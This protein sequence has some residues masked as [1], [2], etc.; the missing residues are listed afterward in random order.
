M[1]K[2]I[3]NFRLCD[4]FL[5]GLILTIST[6]SLL[7]IKSV[8]REGPDF[9][10][11][12]LFAV[13]IGLI[14]AL[15]LQN[16]DYNR[17][18]KMWLWIAI[19]S[20]LL[21]I[22]TFFFGI[23]VEGTLGVNAKAWIKIFGG[24]TFQ[25]SELVKIGFIITF[26]N[27][28]S[29]LQLKDKL[30]DFKHL[31]LVMFHAIL[32]MI[33]MHFQGDDGAA[34]IFFCITLYMMFTAGIKL[35]YFGIAL[36]CATIALPILWNFVMP[37]YQKHRILNQLNPEADPL[38][39]GYQQIQG[40]LSIGSGGIFGTGLFNG[41]RVEN[42]FVPIQESDFI[43]SVVGEELG[44]IGCLAIIFLIFLLLLKIILISKKSVNSLGSLICVGIVGFIASQ[45]M[46]NLGMCLSMLPVIG[47]TLPFFSAGGSSVT[48]LYLTIGLAQNINI[49]NR[50]NNKNLNKNISSR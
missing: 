17:I 28:L 40:K 11:I 19:F 13:V 29:K 21:L 14:C 48:C 27:H 4:K 34:I 43:F 31:I 42:K 18:A 1:L 47:V 30:N 46:F 49:H 15:I 33:F 16:I 7:L 8:S 39:M 25:P 23:A 2:V 41:I 12:Q 35:R 32:P 5:W 10:T 3:E 38:N 24:I 9:F 44:F 36:V 26:A 45:S 50:R 22:Y 6:Y 20:V 37:P